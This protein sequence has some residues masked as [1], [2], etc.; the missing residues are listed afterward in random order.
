MF[1][2]QASSEVIYTSL[3]WGLSRSAGL[4][5][6]RAAAAS[7]LATDIWRCVELNPFETSPGLMSTRPTALMSTGLIRR[8]QLCLIPWQ[9]AVDSLAC[10]AT[11]AIARR[12]FG[13]RNSTRKRIHRHRAV[14]FLARPAC[15]CH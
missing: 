13:P 2:E 4:V 8:R 12:H 9:T 7:G 15:F 3:A 5:Y 6:L 11:A 1:K 14:L 10:V